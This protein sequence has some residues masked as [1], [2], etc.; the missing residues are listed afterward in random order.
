[1]SATAKRCI[2][3]NE[4]TYTNHSFCSAQCQDEYNEVSERCWELNANDIDNY[5]YE[6]NEDPPYLDDYYAPYKKDWL[7]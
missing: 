5:Q 3:C 2:V 7:E 4:L 6:E 1:M